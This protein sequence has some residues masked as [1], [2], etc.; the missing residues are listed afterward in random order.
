MT[1]LRICWFGIYD[2]SYP[3]NDI[4][5]R[6]LRTLCAD[7]IEVR[8]DWRDPARHRK[9]RD[10]LRALGNDYDLVYAAYPSTMP[11]IWAKL[12]SRKPVVMDALYSMYDAV[13]NDRQEVPPYHPRAWKLWLLDWASALFADYLI[14]DTEQHR[15]YWARFP[16]V[17]AGKMEVVYT[18]IQ[19]H[20]FHPGASRAPDGTF[21]ASFHGFYIPLQGVDKIAEAAHLLQ[22]N[23]RIRFRFIGSGQLSKKVNAIIERYGLTNVEQVGRLPVEEVAARSREADAIL[24]IFGDTEKARRV[25]PNKVY[26]G[27]GLRKPVITMDTPAIREQF[28]ERDLMLVEN[29]PAAIAA[30]IQALAADPERARALADAGHEKVT[31]LFSPEPLGRKLLAFLT[32][33]ARKPAAG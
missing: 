24:G 27:M 22:N 20:L 2:P 33:V 18:G 29:T 8:A 28:D 25:I 11:V 6:G 26:E 30:A 15:K 5:M 4:L 23:P 31:R 7:I 17:R 13:V 19:D 1:P 32:E 9:L 3:R 10:G 14:V 21:L 16:F 12:I